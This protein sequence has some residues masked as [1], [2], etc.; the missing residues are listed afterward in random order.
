MP[1][2]PY[3]GIAGRA[4]PKTPWKAVGTERLGGPSVTGRK[5]LLAG[6][7]EHHEDLFPSLELSVWDAMPVS[8]EQGSRIQE[9]EQERPE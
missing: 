2:L 1:R 7:P 6:K 3:G 9:A 4:E 8:Q 5:V